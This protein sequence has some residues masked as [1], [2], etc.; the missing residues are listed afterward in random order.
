M[1]DGLPVDGLA[2]E[3]ALWCRFCAGIDEDGQPIAV[4]DNNAAQ[5]TDHAIRA[6]KNPNV[7]LQQPAIFGALSEAKPFADA[8]AKALDDLWARGVVQVLEERI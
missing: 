6:R 1:R 7:F 4:P 5:L 3:V 8:F 2:L